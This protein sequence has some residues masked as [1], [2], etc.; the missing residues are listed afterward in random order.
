VSEG[1]FDVGFDACA[2]SRHDR[3]IAIAIIEHSNSLP[4]VAALL[5]R[6]PEDSGHD[7]D[8]WPSRLGDDLDNW[9]MGAEGAGSG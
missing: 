3:D 5:R 2:P 9:Q 7:K 8:P 6:R 1:A 4:L